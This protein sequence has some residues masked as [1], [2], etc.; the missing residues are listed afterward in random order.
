M[1][2]PYY[3]HTSIPYFYAYI[4]YIL[5]KTINCDKKTISIMPKKCNVNTDYENEIYSYKI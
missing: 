4:T 3:L 2:S 1:S 5:I